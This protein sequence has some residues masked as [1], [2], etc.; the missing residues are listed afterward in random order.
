[1]RGA[2]G[3]V[4]KLGRLGK[5]G[6]LGRLGILGCLIC[7]ICLIRLKKTSLQ[8]RLQYHHLLG[9]PFADLDQIDARGKR[10]ECC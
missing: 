6:V 8:A 7:L 4:G 9:G 5:L 3:I 1:M 2:L 10:A